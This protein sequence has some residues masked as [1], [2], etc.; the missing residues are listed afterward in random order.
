MKLL[1]CT[2]LA[3]AT[4]VVGAIVASP[5]S[6]SAG[7]IHDRTINQQQRVYH[8]IQNGT[9]TGAEYRKLE[10]REAS[11]ALQRAYYI[12]TRG[13]LQPWEKAR[14]NNRLDNISHS[15]YRDKHD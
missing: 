2:M 14:L 11:V 12:Q 10:R 13:G 1:T 4:A 7:P 8:G 15:I 3:A 5:M 6:A 9:V